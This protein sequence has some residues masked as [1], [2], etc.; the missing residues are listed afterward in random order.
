MSNE[1]ILDGAGCLLLV[2]LMKLLVVALGCLMLWLQTRLAHLVTRWWDVLGDV[3]LLAAP[4]WH[5]GHWVVQVRA[6]L[7]IN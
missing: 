4:C 1:K 6:D 3:F 7:G 2:D 5:W